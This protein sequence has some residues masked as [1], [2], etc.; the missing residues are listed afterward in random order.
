M[1]TIR[2]VAKV[3]GVSAA[4]VSNVLNQRADRVSAE[5]RDKVLAA[6]RSLKYRPGPAHQFHQT[7]R[8]RNIGVLIPN[9]APRP[10][11]SDVYTFGVLN[12]ILEAALMREWTAT[13]Y[14]DILWRENGQSI[15]QRYD[16]RCDGIVA[17]APSK[18]RDSIPVLVERGVPIVQIGT[19]AWIDGVSSVDVDNFAIGVQAAEHLYGLGHRSL[20]FV[21]S[22]EEAIAAV[23]RLD[24]FS[25]CLEDYQSVS[26]EKF[27]VGSEADLERIARLILESEAKP[28]C[29][30]CWNDGVA[31][32]L[33]KVLS[34]LG[35]SVPT[36]FSVV[37]VNNDTSASDTNDLTTFEQDLHTIGVQAATMLIDHLLDEEIRPAIVRLPAQFIPRSSSGPAPQLDR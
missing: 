29:A 13:I 24:G 16:G 19:T 25:S 10:L 34:T 11:T 9:F 37:G 17:I 3:S 33:I 7:V 30:F 14:A 15:R 1:A 26:L 27:A 4:T 21:G 5:T 23:E 28:T 36:A 6:V 32:S 31:R 2:D 8:V 12:G 35:V 18:Q 20:C 22:K